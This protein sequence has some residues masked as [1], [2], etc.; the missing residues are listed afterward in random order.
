MIIFILKLRKNIQL[1]I[2]L[3]LTLI[4]LARLISKFKPVEFELDKLINL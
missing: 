2:R 4:T 1:A 3:L